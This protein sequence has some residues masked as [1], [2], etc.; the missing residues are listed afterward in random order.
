MHD[1]WSKLSDSRRREF[2]REDRGVTRRKGSRTMPKSFYQSATAMIESRQ[3][4]RSCWLVYGH[5]DHRCGP[6]RRHEISCRWLR[7][8][9]RNDES[10]RIG[11][12]KKAPAHTWQHRLNASSDSTSSFCFL[13]ITKMYYTVFISVLVQNPLLCERKEFKMSY[14]SHLFALQTLMLTSRE[15]KA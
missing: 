10:C 9:G 7:Q 11:L 14:I 13:N 3:I 15:N 4:G 2:Y 1:Y 5:V 12:R 6:G 8:A